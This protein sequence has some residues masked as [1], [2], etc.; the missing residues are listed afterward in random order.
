MIRYIQNIPWS[1]SKTL[2]F[3][4]LYNDKNF[5]KVEIPIQT[6]SLFITDNNQ[7]SIADG[8][9]TC[10]YNKENKQSLIDEDT[11]IVFIQSI[12]A[13]EIAIVYKLKKEY[14]EVINRMLASEYSLI[15]EDMKSRI[16][17]FW[18]GYNHNNIEYPVDNNIL[19][20]M[21]LYP[22]KYYER[23][24]EELNIDINIIKK[25]RELASKIDFSKEEVLEI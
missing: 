14:S 25:A 23:V 17:R 18:G 15:A 20:D 21:I 9:L 24:A 5:K 1:K 8:Y 2:L 11:D 6:Y 16:Y 13:N 4:L 22:Y 3:P 19:L 12:N 10:L 7:Y